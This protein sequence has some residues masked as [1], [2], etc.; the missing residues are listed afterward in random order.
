[1]VE[2]LMLSLLGERSSLIKVS[3]GWDFC[4]VRL[5]RWCWREGV[6]GE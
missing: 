3:F 6:S 1:M 4:C 5:L 2:L